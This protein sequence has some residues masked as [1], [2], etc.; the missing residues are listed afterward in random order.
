MT[1]FAGYYICIC[2]YIYIYMCVFV[3]IEK[4]RSGEC[5]FANIDAVVLLKS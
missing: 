5:C 3:C 1:P 4:G 2:V